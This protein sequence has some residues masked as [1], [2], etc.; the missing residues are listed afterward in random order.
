M[1]FLTTR[2]AVERRPLIV[3]M[4]FSSVFVPDITLNVSIFSGDNSVLLLETEPA[5]G[6]C[7][8]LICVFLFVLFLD[9]SRV[10]RLTGS[11]YL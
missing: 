8:A 9:A 6:V 1:E 3:Y 2:G 10:D 4:C 5:V 11:Q 7:S